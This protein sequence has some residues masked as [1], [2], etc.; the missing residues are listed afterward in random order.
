MKKTGLV[1]LR[2]AVKGIGVTF[3]FFTFLSFLLFSMFCTY[4]GEAVA[5]EKQIKLRLAQFTKDNHHSSVAI[6]WWGDEFMKRTGGKV[7]VEYYFGQKLVKMK[8]QFDALRTGMADL[9][10]YVAV[11]MPAKAPIFTIGGMPGMPTDDFY[12]TVVAAQKLGKTE[13]AQ[14]EFTGNNVHFLAAVGH[15]GDF[16]YSKKP[17]NRLE[18]IKG[19]NV[20]TWGYY[21]HAFK[22]WGANPVSI[23]SPE[24]YDA[25]KRG[26]ADATNKPL[27][28]GVSMAMY[29]ISPYIMTPKIG[30]NVVFPLVMNLD[31]WKRLPPDIQKTATE[32]S[33]EFPKKIAEIFEKGD[34]EAI[35]KL[36]E[37]GATFTK[38]PDKDVTKMREMVA[39]LLDKWADDMN[40]KGIPGTELKNKYLG[41]LQGKN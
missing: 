24:I 1:A 33:E 11:W 39:S 18:D 6:K 32:V 36:K 30:V 25:I 23:P 40:K 37:K 26:V 21:S 22:I 28:Q 31:T 34:Q 15:S 3:L 2:N 16:I 5:A 4:G 27:S 13:A 35:A 8:Q 12:T 29:E 19:I 14:K 7:K 9:G 17:I 41:W 10:C 20:A 38:L